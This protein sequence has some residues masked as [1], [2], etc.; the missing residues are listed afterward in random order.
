VPVVGSDRDALLARARFLA[1]RWRRKA[2]AVLREDPTAESYLYVEAAW[3]DFGRGRAPFVLFAGPRGGMHRV[4]GQ[5]VR[6]DEGRL[7]VEAPRGVL[8]VDTR[9]WSATW[10]DGNGQRPVPFVDLPTEQ[11]LLFGDRGLYAGQ[12]IGTPCE[13]QAP[14][15]PAATAA[16]AVAPAA[17]PAAA[18]TAH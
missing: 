14:A 4:A 2:F 17:P 3:E 11:D 6:L 12:V 9:L 1:P 15:A 7:V 8:H 16:P 18:P 13:W 5:R 10:D